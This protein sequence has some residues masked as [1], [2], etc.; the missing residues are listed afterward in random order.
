M[1]QASRGIPGAVV[2]ILFVAGLVALTGSHPR[3]ADAG[4]ALLY[5]DTTA[6]TISSADGLC[7]LREAI[8]AAN[9]NANV[10][11]C[12]AGSGFDG[13]EFALGAGNPVIQIGA[14]PLPPITDSVEIYGGIGANRVVLTGPG[15]GS[16]VTISG[17]GAAGS[18]LRGL[19]LNNFTTAIAISSTSNVTVAGNYIGTNAA[20]N[21]VSQNSVGLSLTAASATIGGLNGLT[22]GGPC[23]GDCNLISGNSLGGFARGI[24]LMNSSSATI[25]GNFIGT[26]LS[27]MFPLPNTVGIRLDKSWAIVGGT[28][29]GAANV[30]SGNTTGIRIQTNVDMAQGSLI[31]GNRIGT[32]VLGT[33]SVPN[34]EDGIS[35]YF[36][37]QDYPLTIGGSAAGAGNVISGNAESGVELA[38]ADYVVIHGNVIGMQADETSPLPNGDAGVRLSSSTHSNVIGGVGAGEGNVIAYNGATGVTVGINNYYNQIRGNS[39]HDNTGKG[40]Q[41]NDQQAGYAPAPPG[42]SNAT[43]SGTSG[44][45][46]AGCVIDVY[47]DGADEGRVYEGSTTADGAGNWVFS[48]PITGPNVTVTATTADSSTSEFATPFTL[49]ATPTPTPSATP[50]PTAT[51]TPSMTPTA[52]PTTTPTPSATSTPTSAAT[53]SPTPTA[54]PTPTPAPSITATPGGL[55]QGDVDCSG[56]VSS[57]DALK[58]LRFVAQLNV[59][60]HEP[61]PD[62]GDDVASIWGDVDCSGSVTSVDALKILR[63]VAELTVAQSEPCADIGT[64][65]N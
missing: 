8:T 15:S 12:G 9:A 30:I 21:S 54:T 4:G 26:D 57:V 35:A 56:G 23:T 11:N 64:P 37:N 52:T 62:I 47:S 16:G 5:V 3:H 58:E 65:D 14:T 7:S 38:G 22:T 59:S 1:P 24:D 36:G 39:I 48:G 49:P 41:L 33:A 53:A 45:T 60:Q 44:T 20:G 19:V 2:L 34:V 28:T 42:I 27:G 40:I 46:C 25:R 31:Q 13:I 43:Q 17:A 63:H 29:A 10:A 18:A 61:C 51:S 6:D 50:T 32:N 55:T